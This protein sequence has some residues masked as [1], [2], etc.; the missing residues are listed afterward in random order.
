[1]ATSDRHINFKLM[2]EWILAHQDGE[3]IDRVLSAPPDVEG[4]LS[5]VNHP[6]ANASGIDVSQNGKKYTAN[7][8]LADENTLNL[9]GCLV[10]PLCQTQQWTRVKNPPANALPLPP[11]K[12]APVSQTK[13]PPPAKG[14]AK[15]P[16]QP[17]VS[18]QITYARIL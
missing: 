13:S 6:S 11:I 7:I 3:R 1:M 10:W 17:A 12:S 4:A 16:A 18:E 5:T 15:G 8:S 14:A 9:E 2:R